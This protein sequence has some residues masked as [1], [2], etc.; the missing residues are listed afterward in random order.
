MSSN[1]FDGQ[2]ITEAFLENLNSANTIADLIIQDDHAHK[3]NS[4]EIIS[5][6]SAIAKR[7]VGVI[8]EQDDSIN[9]NTVNTINVLKLMSDI[10]DNKISIVNQ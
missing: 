9:L 4:L 2:P 3:R 7:I 1:L 6:Q 10:F 5:R 8:D